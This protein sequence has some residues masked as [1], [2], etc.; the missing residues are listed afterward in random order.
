MGLYY[1]KKD[2]KYSLVVLDLTTEVY[3]EIPLPSFY[4][5]YI[6]ELNVHAVGGYLFLTTHSQQM[7]R[8]SL[9]ILKDYGGENMWTML[10]RREYTSSLCKEQR[11]AYCPMESERFCVV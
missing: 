2:V 11:A 7:E 5:E 8:G 9:W 1:W 3:R 4:R 10:I 6:S